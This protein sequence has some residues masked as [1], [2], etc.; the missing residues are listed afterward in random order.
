MTIIQYFAALLV[1]G[2]MLA[3]LV[4]TRARLPAP[5]AFVRPRALVSTVARGRLARALLPSARAT[6]TR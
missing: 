6:R 4:R 5:R 1:A 3:Y 2:A